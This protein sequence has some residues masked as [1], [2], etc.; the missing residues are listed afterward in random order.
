MRTSARPRAGLLAAGL[1]FALAGC[2]P[3]PAST[4]D[5]GSGLRQGSIDFESC[6]LSAVGASAVEARCARFEVP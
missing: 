1:A 2:T 4:E 6:S 5:A 3:P